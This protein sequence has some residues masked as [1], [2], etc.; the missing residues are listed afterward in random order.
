MYEVSRLGLDLCGWGCIITKSI[1]TLLF[2]YESWLVLEVLII[3]IIE[4]DE[5]HI[6]LL[7]EGL[8][9]GIKYIGF[10]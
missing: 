4:V 10:L 2:L 8:V 9:E 3:E 6:H 7:P 1:F 5:L